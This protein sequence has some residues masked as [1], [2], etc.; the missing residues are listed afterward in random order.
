MSGGP[1]H[2]S[3]RFSD[4]LSPD[5]AK[6]VAPSA[7]AFGLVVVEIRHHHLRSPHA[8]RP[9]GDE[10]A[11]RTG[12]EDRHPVA[13]LH[14]GSHDAVKRHRKRLGESGIGDLHAVGKDMALPSRDRDVLRIA[15]ADQIHFRASRG[16]PCPAPL[17]M[18]AAAH[19]NH[20][21]LVAGLERGHR[22]AYGDDL[23]GDLVTEH[24]TLADPERHGILGD[25]EIAAADAAGGHPENDL[26]IPG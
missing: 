23:A 19:R 9:E 10:K 5:S 2:R 21:H 6:P 18:A 4:S 7:R 12:A 1:P 26:V 3:V 8:S 13:D 14:A 11:D 16:I 25:V 15:A 22:L 20:R 17:A 24:E